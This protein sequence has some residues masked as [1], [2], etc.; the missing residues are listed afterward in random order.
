MKKL[1]MLAIVLISLQAT[2]QDRKEDHKDSRKGR[3]EK[4]KNISADDM[5][6]LQTKKMTLHLDLT[7]AQQKKIGELNLRDAKKRKVKIEK[8]LKERK[9]AKKRSQEELI[10]MQNE[11]LDIQI[12]KK[13]EIKAILTAEQYEKWEKMQAKRSKQ[14]KQR[15]MRGKKHKMHDRKEKKREE[16]DH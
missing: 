15:K 13:K 3:V 6:Q 2:A 4:M 5:A 9:G 16:N 1:A 14:M 12:A 8:R 11:K 7:K 10:K